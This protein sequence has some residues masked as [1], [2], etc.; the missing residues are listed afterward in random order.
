MRASSALKE[1]SSMGRLTLPHATFFSLDGSA[2]TNLSLGD[3]PVNLPVLHTRG[4]SADRNPSPRFT[5]SSKRT[6]T[7]GFQ[8]TLETLPSPTAS[9]PT[10]RSADVTCD[11]TLLQAYDKRIMLPHWIGSRHLS[12]LSA[13]IGP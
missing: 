3:R 6:A 10:F 5:A 12:A 4:P 13:G 11:I 8:W 2:T 1:A 7:L 9:N